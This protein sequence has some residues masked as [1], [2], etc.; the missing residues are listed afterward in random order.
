MPVL[1]VTIALAAAA[2]SAGMAA[3]AAP[4]APPPHPQA[5]TQARP[6]PTRSA[7]L[8]ADATARRLVSQMTR[9]EKLRLVFGYFGSPQHPKGYAPPPEARMGSAGYV[10]GVPRLGIPPQW[11]TD[12]SLGVATQ[13]D[14][15]E[16]Y[17][18]RTSLPSSLATAATFDPA[19]ARQGGVMIGREARASGFNVMLAGGMNLVREP[20]DGRNFEYSGEDPLLAGVMTGAAVRGVQSDHVIATVKHFALNAQ[21][22]GRMVA[23]AKISDA[24]ARAS[25]LLAFQFA[26]EQGRPGAVMCAY[27]RFNGVYACENPD[28]LGMLKGE[29]KYPGFVM[30]DWGAMHGAAAAANA[31]LDQESGYILDEEPYFGDALA[32]AVAAGEVPTSRLD[33]MAF[34]IVRSM[35]AEGLLDHP[36]RPGGAIDLEADAK[37]SQADEAS[38]IVLLKNTAGLLPLARGAERI[39]VI[40]GHADKGVIAG[41]GSSTVFPEGVT[42][43]PG[44]EPKTWP[45]PVVFDPAPPLAAILARAGAEHV[46]WTD[47]D[48]LDAAVKAAR[49]ADLVIVFGTQWTAESRD[50]ALSLD[51]RQ[52]ELIS[53]VAA[54]NPKSVVVLETGGP[55]LMPWLDKAGAVLEAW[56][57]GSGGGEA[58]AKVLFGE[59]DASGRLPVTFPR[60]ESQ[61]PRPRLDGQGLTEGAPF[62]VDYDIEGAAV[63][64]KWFDRQKLEPLFPFGWGLSYTRFDYSD[65]KAQVAGGRLDVSFR[66]RNI[67]D[68]PGEAVPQIYVSAPDSGWEAPKRL[69]G[70]SKLQLRPGESRRVYLAVDPRLLAVWDEA[71]RDWKISR[72]ELDV[73]LGS[74]SRD[75]AAQVSV[76]TPAE[77]LPASW[78]P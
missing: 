29:W 54:A 44:L 30:S 76:V 59:V 4:A 16:P 77:R 31:G 3:A 12:A 63:G 72:G 62:T 6:S 66:V 42:A 27:N 78:R 52:D 69:A 10:P 49:A 11:E 26:I 61:L 22:T 70:W 1:K 14:S 40:G 48:D 2:A 45:G 28:L 35:A 68:R 15:T 56:Y 46:T 53:A 65:L 32:R 17:R 37:V 51:G 19:L 20:R 13:R 39:A 67:G 60:D 7:A 57:P 9:A 34:R 74:S 50:A 71:A 43:V 55:V 18:V 64:Y 36:T 58:I 73:L 75:I 21:E 24:A 38:A 47:G 23:N 25:D 8:S 33:D 41:G 5:Q